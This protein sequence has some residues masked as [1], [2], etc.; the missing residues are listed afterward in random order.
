M[1]L[2]QDANG[3]A[4]QA[5]PLQKMGRRQQL[6]DLECWWLLIRIQDWWDST[7]CIAVRYT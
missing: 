1:G 7:G 2:R 3:R 4:E 6:G 5:P